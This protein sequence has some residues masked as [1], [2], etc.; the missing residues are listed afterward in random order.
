[1]GLAL[2]AG[3]AAS[4]A[5]AGTVF[6]WDPAGASPGLGGAFTADA[7]DAT[8]YL[9]DIAPIANPS[10]MT[11]TVQ[12]LEQITGFTLDGTPATPPGLNGP[13]G[14]PGS[15][16]LYLTMQTLAASVG[17]P[18]IYQYL[19]GNVAL[20]L[21][22]GNDDGVASSTPLGL[23]FANPGNTGNDVPLATG[24][25]VSGHYTLN[26]APGI[27]SIGDFVQTFQPAAG[28][29][30]FFVT[31]VS[32]HDLINVVPTTPPPAIQF[33]PYPSDPTLQ[34][35]VL[36]GGSTAIDFTVPEPTSFLLLGSGLIGLA[37][38]RRRARKCEPRPAGRCGFSPFAP[39]VA[40]RC[41]PHSPSFCY[42]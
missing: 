22:P 2:A 30:A 18:N 37:A 13:L 15:Y 29:G 19:S 23:T 3:A 5:S 35:S 36:N 31:P 42:R 24:S 11:H 12:Y 17:P 8:H 21:D 34:I 14:A 7:I 38:L 32:P 33:F 41:H 9:Y 20:M 16:G 26:P 6:T 25:L 10:P 39:L 4:T 40:A 28:A 1:M 27:R